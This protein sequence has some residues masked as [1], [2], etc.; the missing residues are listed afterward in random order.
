[1]VQTSTTSTVHNGPTSDGRDWRHRA[2]YRDEDPELFHPVGDDGP[3]LVQ[4]AVA[5][6]VCARCPVVADCLSY[7]LVVL[8]EGVAGGLT[9]EQRATLRRTR[10]SGARR[11]VGEA[12]QPMAAIEQQPPQG[13]QAPSSP[14]QHED[15][16]GAYGDDRGELALAE[17]VA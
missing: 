7:A 14:R 9:A 6:A 12:H 1:M 11:A 4:I 2:A 15:Q 8:P 17:G 3:A 13:N 10:R 16:A 5:T